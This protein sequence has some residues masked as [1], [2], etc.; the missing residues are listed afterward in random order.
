M[1]IFKLYFYCFAYLRL[2]PTLYIASSGVNYYGFSNAVL[3]S[4]ILSLVIDDDAGIN[5]CLEKI[6]VVLL[7]L[8]NVYI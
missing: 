3:K 6:D 1:Y 5:G 8:S 2:L 4:D 7:F